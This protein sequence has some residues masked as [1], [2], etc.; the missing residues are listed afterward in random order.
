MYQTGTLLSHC[1]QTWSQ[2]PRV[3]HNRH[4]RTA[5]QPTH[6]AAGPPTC[7][8]RR[9]PGHTAAPPRPWFRHQRS[10]YTRRSRSEVCEGQ[11]ACG[12]VRESAMLILSDE[13]VSAFVNVLMWCAAHHQS[14]WCDHTQRLHLYFVFFKSCA[15]V[16]DVTAR[17]LT[18]TNVLMNVWCVTRCGSTQREW[19]GAVAPEDC[20][21]QVEAFGPVG[22]TTR[23]PEERHLRWCR[24][25]VLANVQLVLAC[26]PVS[27][28]P[29]SGAWGVCA[30]KLAHV[31]FQHESQIQPIRWYRCE[32]SNSCSARVLPTTA[33]ECIS[34][35]TTTINC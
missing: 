33:A 12:I 15:R 10:T 3:L 2:R 24:R 11:L 8:Q 17:M 29:C 16:Y 22:T 30:R 31:S 28:S 32:R 27:V 13:R 25:I 34:T 1:G 21:V 14:E 26:G 7:L 35:R 23:H 9:V 19:H 6:S 5:L 18:D 4:C 20:L